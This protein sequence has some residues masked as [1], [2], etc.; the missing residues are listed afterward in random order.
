MDNCNIY[1]FNSSLGVTNVLK[2]DAFLYHFGDVEWML[3]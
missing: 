3:N 1:D 2:A